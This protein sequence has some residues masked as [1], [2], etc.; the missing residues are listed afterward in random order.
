MTNRHHEAIDRNDGDQAATA[1]I[2][3]FA[4]NAQERI[5]LRPIRMSA[6]CSQTANS[7]T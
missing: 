7:R 2:R 4:E 3:Q 6:K 5:S 1:T